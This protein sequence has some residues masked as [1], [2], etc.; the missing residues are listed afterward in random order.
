MNKKL[1]ELLDKI[2][3][4]KLEVK[5]LAEQGKLEEAKTAKEELKN[6]QTQFDLLKDLDDTA[7][8]GAQNAMVSGTGVKPLEK[9]DAVKEFAEAAR[10]GFRNA[11]TGMSEGTQADGGYTV[12]EDIQTMI[13]TYRDAKF[14]LMSLVRVENVTTSKGARTFK[15]RAQQTGFAK[16]GEKG[17]IQGK[18][19]PQFERVDYEIA[20]YAGYFPV[21][22]ELLADSDANIA[23][24]LTEWIGDESRV[25]ANNL[26]LE[27]IHK[28]AAVNVKDLDGIKKVLNVDLGAA[29]KATASIVTNDNGLQ[30]LD[31]LKDNNGRYLLSPDPAEPMQMRLAAGAVYIPVQVVP[32]TDLPNAEEYVQTQD[33]DV[34]AGKTYYTKVEEVYTKVESPAKSAIATYYEIESRIPMIIGDLNEGIWYFDR[35]QRTIMVSTTAA[36]GDLNAFEQDLTIYRAIEREDVKTRDSE[37][38]VNGYIVA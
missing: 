10:N 6:M 27:E 16:V 1:L 24:T 14:S 23:G 13:N 29:F 2:N 7:L 21:T 30:Y 37:A 9:K 11:V 19:T 12:P 33:K 38:F 34:V 31:T 17:K 22:N 25:T 8:A 26:I 32:N 3:A 20:K 35:A 5:N 15:K 18:E 28:K 4:K 36:V